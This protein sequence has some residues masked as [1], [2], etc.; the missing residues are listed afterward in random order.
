MGHLELRT[1]CVTEPLSSQSRSVSRV[2]RYQSL[3]RLYYWLANVFQTMNEE[4]ISRLLLGLY[5]ELTEQP[6][7]EF[8]D[9]AF[10]K[11]MRA[12]CFDSGYIVHGYLNPVSGLQ[13]RGINLFRQPPE[14]LQDYK[15]IAH[16]DSVAFRTARHQG[17]VHAYCMNEVFPSG[18]HFEPIRRFAKRHAVA[19]SMSF[20]MPWSDNGQLA[21]ISLS[22]SDVTQPFSQHDKHL[23]GMLLPHLIQCRYQALR[24]HELASHQLPATE[25]QAMCSLAGCL[26]HCPD[27]VLAMMQTEWPM[28]LP[29][30]L[31]RVLMDVL[32]SS[33]PLL[34][35]GRNIAVTGQLLGAS[36]ILRINAKLPL[37]SLT[38][39]Q[40]DT[41]MLVVRGL[42]YKEVAEHLGLSVNTVRN[43]LTLVYH[44][45]KVRNKTELSNHWQ[46]QHLE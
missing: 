44:K 42:S 1:T 32:A 10:Q 5:R 4:H 26:S 43:H 2:C 7:T 25:W 41:A 18:A 39:A 35:S 17:L 29:P 34:Y 16:L 19:H 33:R 31:P 45:L 22:R 30:V 28:W 3:V 14:K 37:A 9:Y 36:L 23:A 8:I 15:E 11:M 21:G 24:L 38:P 46:H 20:A 12:L 6:T 13:P 27:A 40:K